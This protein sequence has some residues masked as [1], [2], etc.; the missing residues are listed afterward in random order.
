MINKMTRELLKD[1]LDF[2]YERIF[3]SLDE[4][5]VLVPSAVSTDYHY[6][7]VENRDW[8]DGFWTGMLHLANEYRNSA[9]IQMVISKQLTVFQK[10]L[11]HE[12]VLNHHDLGFLYSPSAVA[13]YRTNFDQDA[14]Q[15]A[16][17]AAEVLMR[18]YQPQ[19]KII[20]AWGELSDPDQQ[21]RMII[22]CNMNLPLLFFSSQVTGNLAYYQ[23]AKNHLKRA[24]KFLVRHDGSTYHTFYMDTKTGAP[25]FGR[26]AQGY[27][28]ESC[29]AR[30]QSWAIYGFALGYR[31][32]K[33]ASLLETAKVVADYFISK[34]PADFVCYWDLSFGTDSSEER[35]TSAA[36]VAASGLLELAQQ[37]PVTDPKKSQYEN[38]ALEIIRSLAQNYTTRGIAGSNGI[39]TQG[40]YSK[41]ENNGVDECTTWG[42]YFY[43]EALLRSYQ[44]WLSY[45]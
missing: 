42:D 33:D 31:Y 25:R 27:S 41:P 28:D 35:D 39:L 1:E 21:G 11:D 16:I 12:I 10:R 6:A 9:K 13:E 14:K 18:R 24:Q 34:C 38:F 36:A 7:A 37:L 26:T 19:A 17:Q 2:A 22:D 45:W 29:W 43:F 30:G 8:T 3:E 20:Q 40:V 23:A 44:S 32:L 4:F 15:M 5:E